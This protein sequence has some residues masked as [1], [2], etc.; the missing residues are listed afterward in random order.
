MYRLLILFAIIILLLSHSNAQEIQAPLAPDSRIDVLDKELT[1]KFGLFPEY[2]NISSIILFQ[3]TDGSYILEISYKIDGK[4]ARVRKNISS[5]E[6]AELRQKIDEKLQIVAPSMLINQEGRIKLLA[7]SLALGLSAWGWM[8]PEGFRIEDNKAYFAT[9][10]L[11]SAGSFFIPYYLTKESPVSDA[12]AMLSFFGGV[13]GIMNG[14]FLYEFFT[15][16]KIDS[17]DIYG[18]EYYED[19]FGNRALTMGLTSIAQA[20]AGYYIATLTKME[21][22]KSVLISG[23]GAMGYG[24]GLGTS[25]I[26][27]SDIDEFKNNA[28]A[29]VLGNIAGMFAGN[30]IANQQHYTSGDA[31]LTLNSAL[32]GTLIPLSII[33]LTESEDEK[34]IAGM[35]MAGNALGIFAGDY[36]IK[37]YD[38]SL[39]QGNLTTLGT[40]AGGF[41]GGGIGY[42][43][44]SDDDKSLFKTVTSMTAMG[45]GIGLGFMYYTFKDDAEV[46][47]KM[48]QLDFDINPLGLMYSL[49]NKKTES[50][51]NYHIPVV[52][53][54]Y[55]F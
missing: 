25:V 26:A 21:E 44:S 39:S 20:V 18:N 49:N 35:L 3:G 8:L 36:L 11:T 6:L 14:A 23:L 19:D 22:G 1:K 52:S 45:A 48:G 53:M 2:S 46:G 55:K 15:E 5:T 16:V 37:G 51:M 38:F 41:L 33:A 13:N 54:S 50:Y 4:L 47:K 28:G 31:L 9:Y 17:V 40:F 7:S 10:L 43:I 27:G 42:L 30:F 12:S 32:V 34:A 24:Y 29:M